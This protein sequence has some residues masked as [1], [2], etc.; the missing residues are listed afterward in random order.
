[1][2]YKQ[3]FRY[4]V[5]GALIMLVGLGLGAIVSPPLIAQK[6]SLLDEVR[7]TKLTVVDK[8]DKPAMILSSDEATGNG[9]ILFDQAGKEAAVLLAS[10]QT[11]SLGIYNKV[12]I[13][14]VSLGSSEKGSDLMLVN[15]EGKMAISLIAVKGL[16]R[17]LTVFNEEGKEAVSLS[18]INEFSMNNVTVFNKAGKS[19]IELDSNIRGN[20]VSIYDKAGNVNWASP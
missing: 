15:E 19:A 14:A 8:Y 16:G 6:Y 2:N 12:G 7:C 18:S 20:G 9:I 10:K 5:L 17:I 11:N 13:P 1:M 4:T 3:K